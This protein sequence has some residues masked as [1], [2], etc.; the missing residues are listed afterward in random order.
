MSV[1]QQCNRCVMDNKSDK[2]ISFDNH[3]HCNYCS[4]ALMDKSNKYFPDEQGTILLEQK[5]AYIKHK[6]RHKKYDCLMGMS[7]GLDSSYLA[8]LGAIKWKLRILA[9]HIDDGYDTEISRRNLDRLC[10]S[11]QIELIVIKPEPQY[12][13]DL[14][15]AYMLAGVPNLA[16]PQDNTVRAH[17]FK[18]MRK[19]K[20]NIFLSGANFALECILQ[21]GNTFEAYD[22]RNIKD[23]HHRFGKLRLKNLPLLSSFK[24]DFVR[25][26]LNIE[27]F[28]LLDYVDYNREKALAELEKF[29]GFEY[30]GNKHLE[31]KLTKFIQLYWFYNKFGVDKRTSHLSSMIV[32]NQLSREQALFLLKQP[33]YDVNEM[34]LLIDEILHNIGLNRNEFNAILNDEPRSHTDYKIS[35]YI[36][37][38]RMIKKCFKLNMK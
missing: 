1:Y 35:Q 27:T 20:I 16:I 7:G 24:N 34:E 23:I 13:N 31:N 30:Y 5:I 19:E 28:T 38:K 22:L 29:C 33:L 11:A 4:G 9:V 8:Y 2:Y 25:F 32:S 12:F 36:K 15:R 10:Q 18:F 17:I 21:K 6:N 26:I 14:T 37:F 3:G